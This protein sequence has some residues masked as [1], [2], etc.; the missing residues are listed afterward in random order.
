[1]IIYL[2]KE[3]GIHYRLPSF[4][5]NFSHFL[6]YVR[7]VDVYMKK[8]PIGKRTI[9]A[10]SSYACKCRGM[11]NKSFLF[12]FFHSLLS[13]CATTRI[14]IKQALF[15]HR[16]F[17]IKSHLSLCSMSLR[18]TEAC[19]GRMTAGKIRVVKKYDNLCLLEF[20][21]VKIIA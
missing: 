2:K 5:F 1:M 10:E 14:N 21:F 17:I 6:M 20:I 16:I 13:F 3:K 18:T 9:E 15:W 8:K 4:F 11:Q 19:D 12:S 7:I